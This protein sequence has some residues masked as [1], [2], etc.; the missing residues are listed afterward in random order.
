[1]LH[2]IWHITLRL[3]YYTL[4]MTHHTWH[5]THDTSHM[6]HYTPFTLHCFTLHTD[7]HTYREKERARERERERKKETYR[8]TDGLIGPRSHAHIARSRLRTLTVEESQF[9]DSFFCPMEAGQK[10]R[11]DMGGSINGGFPMDGS[12]HGKSESKVMTGGTPISGNPHM[13]RMDRLP[14]RESTD[15]YLITKICGNPK[16]SAKTVWMAMD[17]YG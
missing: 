1:M 9:L 13:D 4:H 7:I 11:G 14:V 15:G 10:R 3:T 17:G 16:R 2:Y 5:V 8:R 12:F 6:T